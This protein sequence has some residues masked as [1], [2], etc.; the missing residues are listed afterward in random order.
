MNIRKI[1]VVLVVVLMCGCPFVFGADAK[2]LRYSIAVTTFEDKTGWGGSW[3]LGDAWAAILTDALTDTGRFIVL[4]EKEMRQAAITEQDFAASDRAAGGGKKVVSGQMTPAQLLIKG[5]ITHFES[6]TSGGSTGVGFGGFNV[7][8]SA[9]KSEVNAVIYV[10][11]SSTGQVLA[12]KKCY[13]EISNNGVSF[14]GYKDGFS[15]N[16][17][18]FSKSNE[19]KVIEIAVKEGVD[20][21]ISKLPDI[22][23]TGSVAMVKDDKVY[24]N[25]GQR[26]GV[27]TGKIFKVGELNEVRDPDTG[28]LL[29]QSVEIAGEVQVVT[30]KDKMSI[31]KVIKGEGITKGMAVSD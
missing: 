29:D 28:E 5:E 17:E 3:N 19:G 27:T 13:G 7:G 31:C 2:G 16:I 25:R 26:E 30:V 10:I 20:Y 22:P 23:W 9:S 12:S 15:G 18:A 1:L 14:D 21:L 11:D 4:G 6:G 8:L 24:I